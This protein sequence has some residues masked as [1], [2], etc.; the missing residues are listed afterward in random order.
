MGGGILA[1]IAIISFYKRDRRNN[2]GYIQVLPAG[3]FIIIYTTHLIT[4]ATTT[5]FNQIDSRL[6]SPIYVF[7][8]FFILYVF[9][10][11][12][13]LFG[14]SPKISRIL[15]I[16][17]FIFFSLWLTY[18]L[19]LTISHVPV[20]MRNGINGFTSTYYSKSPLISWVKKNPHL[21]DSIIYTNVSPHGLYF[22]VGRTTT[23]FN[24]IHPCSDDNVLRN[25][26]MEGETG[27][28]AYLIWLEK[29]K[30]IMLH[31]RQIFRSVFRLEKIVV[32]PDGEVYLI[33][34]MKS[35]N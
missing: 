30:N 34:G 7:I 33:K 19:V 25:L 6:L 32:L 14:R 5:H 1:I 10:G 9:E 11:I 4:S 23:N 27:N 26:Q 12:L 8:I 29:D 3:L 18:R 17:I 35:V 16:T 22:L 28:K 24:F 20:T 13:N 21:L 2:N 31:K 15:N